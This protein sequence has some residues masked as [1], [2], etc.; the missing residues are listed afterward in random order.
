MGP[1]ALLVCKR[2][3]YTCQ[4]IIFQDRA[5]EY[6]PS[7][8]SECTQY[9]HIHAAMVGFGVSMAAFGVPAAIR[10]K[11]MIIREAA[12]PRILDGVEDLN[13]HESFKDVDVKDPVNEGQLVKVATSSSFTLP[14]SM[15]GSAR[16]SLSS[17]PFPTESPS[18]EELSKGS[19]FSYRAFIEKHQQSLS[20]EAT[21]TGDITDAFEF[22]NGRDS[23]VSPSKI[24]SGHVA[25][26]AHYFH[27]EMQFILTLIAISDRLRTVPKHA[28]QGTLV[29]ELTL[30]NHNLPADVCI[31]LWC[32]YDPK[33]KTGHHRVVRLSPTD[34]VIL[35]S[36]ERVPYLIMVEVVNS[37]PNP[38]LAKQPIPPTPDSA[39]SKKSF[40]EE[41]KLSKRLSELSFEG[42]VS[43]H[44]RNSSESADTAEYYRRVLERRQSVTGGTRGLTINTSKPVSPLVTKGPLS[45]DAGRLNTPVVNISISTKAEEYSE[46]MRTAAVMLAQLYQQQLRDNVG[47]PQSGSRASESATSAVA[48]QTPAHA[49]IQSTDTASPGTPVD[50]KTKMAAFDEIRQRLLKE[51]TALEQER[52]EMLTKEKKTTEMLE[53]AE[54]IL[55]DAR[56]EQRMKNESL[57]EESSDPSASV[58]R[59][60][61]EVKRQRIRAA[62]PYGKDPTWQ[63]YSC[64]V[65][66]GAD[67]RQEQLALQLISEMQRIW[68]ESDV[69]VWVYSFQILITSEQSGLIETI[70]DSISVHSIKNEGYAKE[71]NQQGI[72]YTLYDYFIKVKDCDIEKLGEGM[73]N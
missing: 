28:R 27:S 62:S 5:L 30:L 45:G 31:P 41:S 63:L 33:N 20:V 60:R 40:E 21:D 13:D 11:R 6:N 23:I 47:S 10:A 51:M 48:P 70:P 44:R 35:N 68:A 17:G 49:R 58:F 66:S 72:A 7:V 67:L 65:K 16:Q 37:S 38:P 22:P 46:R 2:I 18:L 12:F 52:M 59:E 25:A 34:A 57:D 56:Q 8:G 1:L 36:A 9:C 53:R 61:W 69:P 15:S 42:D 26:T 54:E 64:I 3:F 43:S 73:I 29:A 32:H 55:V 39:A 19:A 24:A 50:S 4:A 14:D 71:L